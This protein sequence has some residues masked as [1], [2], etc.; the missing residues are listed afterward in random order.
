MVNQKKK[1]TKGCEA[2]IAIFPGKCG[3]TDG[4]WPLGLNLVA[5]LVSVNMS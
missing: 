4:A 5:M 1:S 2:F 3:E